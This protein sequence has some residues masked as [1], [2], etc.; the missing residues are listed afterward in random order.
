MRKPTANSTRS[1]FGWAIAIT[2]ALT[3]LLLA[4]VPNALAETS[5]SPAVA[6]DAAIAEAVA[7]QIA[8]DPEMRAAD[9]QAKVEDGVATLTGTS[10]NILAKERAAYLAESVKGVRRVINRIEATPA[11]DID[12]AQLERMIEHELVLTPATESF[13]IEVEANANG[14]VTLRGLVDSW[15]EKQLSGIVAKSVRGVTGLRNEIE[16]TPAENRDD[17][18][19]L[20]E[21]EARLRWDTRVD[22]TQIEVEVEDQVVRLFGVVGSAAERRRAREAARVAGVADVDDQRLRVESWSGAAH[23]E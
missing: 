14:V 18:E 15:S 19:I 20:A 17:N 23:A 21:I 1:P 7:K 10:P 8:Y 5:P 22:E 9:V 16:V 6:S 11:A 2:G 3:A 12:A 4:G 13:E